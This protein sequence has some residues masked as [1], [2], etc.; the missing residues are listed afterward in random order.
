MCSSVKDWIKHPACSPTDGLKN[1]ECDSSH[2]TRNQPRAFPEVIDHIWLITQTR[3]HE[4]A[5]STSSSIWRP[6]GARRGGAG[7]RRGPET[8]S[9]GTGAAQMP[10]IN[11]SRWHGASHRVTSRGVPIGCELIKTYERGRRTDRSRCQ[12]EKQRVSGEKRLGLRIPSESLSTETCLYVSGPQIF[13]GDSQK[14]TTQNAKFKKKSNSMF[15]QMKINIV[16]K[17]SIVFVIKAT[18]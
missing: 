17:L 14:F 13:S 11:Q 12:G 2:V 15:F 10:G 1:W 3:P 7:T 5:H 18:L 8:G 6:G 4:V 9:A 16:D